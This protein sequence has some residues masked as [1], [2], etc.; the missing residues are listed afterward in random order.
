V[1][2]RDCACVRG[3]QHEYGTDETSGNS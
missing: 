3:E 2:F 1:D